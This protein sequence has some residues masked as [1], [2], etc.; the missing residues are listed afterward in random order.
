MDKHSAVVPEWTIGLDLGD[1]YTSFCVLDRSGEVIESGRKRTS[2]ES[3]AKISADYPG[4]RI[5]LETG[6]HSP[7]VCWQFKAWDHEV[8]VAEASRLRAIYENP[9]KSDDCDAEMLARIGRSDPKLLHPIQHRTMETQCLLSVVRQRSALVRA[10]TLLI[11]SVRGTVKSLG[12]RIPKH[13]A[14]SF[15]KR[16]VVSIPP[17]LRRAVAP[18]LTSIAEL[19][20]Q[21]RQA[22]AEM[23]RI[24]R[25]LPIVQQLQSAPSIGPVTALTYVLTIEDP[26]RFRKSRTVGA[27]VGLTR[28]RDDSGRHVSELG[29]TKRG[30]TDLRG[31]LVQAA[32]HLLGPFGQDCPLRR[33]GLALAAK[34]S[35]RRGKKRAVVAVARRYAVILHR[36]W[37]TGAEFELD[38]VA[39]PGTQ[40]RVA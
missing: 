32:Q 40:P 30:D 39:T 7:W 1:K 6:T 34:T 19:T 25:E 10:R 15:A 23:E 17:E 14:D 12:A 4:A 26:Y 29:I 2:K 28:R 3:L 31:L 5:V 18:V 16:A 21:I 22:E 11:N 33:W 9:G 27:Y 13:S 8:F 24:S 36:M 20:H 35:D 37:V 38:E